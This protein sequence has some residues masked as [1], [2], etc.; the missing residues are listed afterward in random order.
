M[1]KLFFTT[2]SEMTNF[3]QARKLEIIRCRLVCDHGMH[4]S[5]ILL[6]DDK[7]MVQYRLLR[8]KL[9]KNKEV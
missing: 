2:R 8:C 1:N 4:C 9:C 3:A 5:S 7:Q 6:I